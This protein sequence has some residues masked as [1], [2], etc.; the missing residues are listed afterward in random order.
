MRNCKGCDTEIDT[1][2]GITA[3]PARSGNS[4]DQEWWHPDCRKAELRKRVAA[5]AT[6]PAARRPARGQAVTAAVDDDDSEV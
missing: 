2:D 3:V 6:K 4:D 1:N 5:S